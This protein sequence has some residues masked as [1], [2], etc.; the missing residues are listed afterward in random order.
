M[1]TTVSQCPATLIDLIDGLDSWGDRPAI[2]MAG[3]TKTSEWTFADVCASTRRIGAGLQRAGVRPGD[4]VVLLAPNRPEWIIAALGVIRAGAILVPVDNQFDD[5]LLAHVINDCKPALVIT[6]ARGE[7]RLRRLLPDTTPAYLLDAPEKSTKSWIFLS[8]ADSLG[9]VKADPAQ[10]A[11]MFYTSGTTGP[12][13]GVPLSHRNLTFQLQRLLELRIA[14]SDDGC[15]LPLP[16]HHVYPFVVGMLGS[17]AFGMCLVLPEV[18]QGPQILWAL[19][20]GGVTIVLGV[21]RLYD[22]MLSGV[23]NQIRARGKFAAALFD[24]VLRLCVFLRRHLKTRLGRWLFRPVRR[25]LGPDVRM[26]VSGG[27]ALDP[28]T[29]WTMEGLGWSVAMGYGLTETSPLISF[30]L[31]GEDQ[32]DSAGRPVEGVDLRIGPG[33]EIQVQGPGVFAGYH[34]LPGRSAEAFTVDGWFRTDD[35][36]HIDADGFLHLSGRGSTLIVTA[37][38]ENVQPDDVED[39][40]AQSPAIREI[41]VLASD[42]GLA[43]VVV[44][45]PRPARKGQEGDVE[46]DVRKAVNEIARTLPSYWRLSD[47]VISHEALQRTRLGKIRRPQLRTRYDSLKAGVAAERPRPGPM[48]LEQM[49]DEDKDLLSI[50]DASLVWG[51]LARRYPDRRLTPDTSPALDLGIDSLEWMAVSLEIQR[52]TGGEI[53]EQAT[54]RIDTVRDLLVEVVRAAQASRERG[55]EGTEPSI[56]RLSPWQRRWLV[57]LGPTARLCARALHATVRVLAF[58]LFRLSVT[59][60]RNLPSEGNFVIA[61]NHTSVLDPFALAAALDFGVLRNTFWAAWTG[62]AFAN[63]LFRGVSRLA[64]AL[65][66]EAGRAA[67][68]SLALAEIVLNEGRNLV[69]FPEGG[70]SRTGELQPFKSGI[71]LLLTKCDVPVV[72]VAISGTFDAMPIGRVFPRPRK[73]KVRFGRPLTISELGPRGQGEQTEERIAA[74]LHDSVA[75]LVARGSSGSDL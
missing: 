30:G 33:G 3:E 27:A 39:A 61:P 37:S 2:R 51:W 40:Y 57:P 70:R 4:H 32:F 47:L 35:L 24:I 56:T 28:K 25:R 6:L 65:P 8:K 22:I 58:A 9:P 16:L 63:P 60:R 38:G 55:V 5:E 68:S 48:P 62:M 18:L 53:T 36:G 42:T 7:Q 73:V 17:L 75:E 74:A 31:P 19:R 12:P 34:N 44:P 29:A 45:A 11:V 71:G 43:A 41:G 23:R 15:L 14:T 26:V 72:P 64:Q 66:I 21:P 10:T 1:D 52:L 20:H 13:K 59:G 69:W 50:Q 49:T 67:F 54:A 46:A